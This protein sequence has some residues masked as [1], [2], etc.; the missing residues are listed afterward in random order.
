MFRRAFPDY[1]DTVH[2]IVAEGDKVVVRW[3]LNGTHE[4]DF[5]GTQATGKRVTTSGI[6]IFRLADGKITDDWTVIDMAGLMRQTAPA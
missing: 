3:T 5:L 2:D 1:R 4:G 6:S